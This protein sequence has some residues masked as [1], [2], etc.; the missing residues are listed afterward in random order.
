L[1][2]AVAFVLAELAFVAVAVAR[3]I[4][5]KKSPPPAAA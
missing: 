2:G 5:L 3:R 4:S 1:P